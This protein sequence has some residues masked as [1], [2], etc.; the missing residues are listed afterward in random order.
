M[1]DDMSG[2]DSRVLAIYW[3]LEDLVVAE[4]DRIYGAGM[5][6]MHGIAAM[7]SA[8]LGRSHRVGVAR[9]NIPAVMTFA[10]TLG[11]PVINRFYADWTRPVM[12]HYTSS[13]TSRPPAEF[14]ELHPGVGL[15][16]QVRLPADVLDDL[17]R[18]PDVTDVLVCSGG[19]GF[20]GLPQWCA[21]TGRTLHAVGITA[22]RN[23]GWR[24]RCEFK[25]YSD[26][27]P[28]RP[29]APPEP[30]IPL[31][32]APFAADP[33]RRRS[34]SSLKQ[35]IQQID[36]AFTETTYGFKRGFRNLLR[37]AA[38]RGFVTLDH[39]DGTSDII[40]SVGPNQPLQ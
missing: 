20:D 15:P 9:I 24:D 21:Q 30:W 12:R 18:N 2:N 34:A 5:W 10:D 37:A 16:L 6:H 3:H 13:A 1:A 29:S 36:S 26:V 17:R 4:Y 31:L 7:E 19:Q 33:T 39:G 40:V 22:T 32:L 23:E 25:N 27:V 14:V 8:Q 35:E 38:E 11:R 28:A